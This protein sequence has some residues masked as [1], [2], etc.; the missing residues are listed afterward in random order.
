MSKSWIEKQLDLPEGSVTPK[1]EY[2]GPTFGQ[3]VW[4]VIMLCFGIW[5]VLHIRDNQQKAEVRQ[6]IH[7]LYYQDK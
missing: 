7:D 5:L 2:H 3:C 1:R 4:L 6:A